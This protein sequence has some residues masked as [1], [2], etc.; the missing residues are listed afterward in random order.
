MLYN[1]L[2]YLWWFNL[3][4]LFSLFI[5]KL[6][7]FLKNLEFILLFFLDKDFLLFWTPMSYI[8]TENCIK[9][10]FTDCVEVCPVECFY[11]GEN[12]LVI[13]PSECIDCAVCVPECPTESI[14]SEYDL[15]IEQKIFIKINYYLSKIWPNI[16]DYKKY[17]F[18]KKWEK[19][20]N[21]LHIV[22]I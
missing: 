18:K 19:I 22:K 2:Y 5:K 1:Y 3:I 4:K 14:Y 16:K 6:I 10:K 17:N 12:F 21:K 15:K 7:F 13:N 9:C 8:V 11:E 20:K